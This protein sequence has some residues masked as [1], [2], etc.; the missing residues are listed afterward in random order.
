MT[1]MAESIRM[2]RVQCPLCLGTGVHRFFYDPNDYFVDESLD[3]KKWWYRKTT[4]ESA[5]WETGEAVHRKTFDPSDEDLTL[6]LVRLSAML[7]AELPTRGN[8]ITVSSQSSRNRRRGG[9]QETPRD[10]FI[11]LRKLETVTGGV[12]SWRHFDSNGY[13]P[14][15]SSPVEA[16]ATLFNADHEARLTYPPDFQIYRIFNPSKH[17]NYIKDCRF[18]PGH[19]K[20]FFEVGLPGKNC[21]PVG[22]TER[23]SKWQEEPVAW[24]MEVVTPSFAHV[25]AT[26]NRAEFNL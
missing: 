24:K 6:D 10:F 3:E 18:Q 26:V 9:L 12:L 4:I 17:R 22:W 15:A 14:V 2:R 13:I 23:D 8:M 19:Y 16:V 1:A 5:L 20:L 21:E 11:A 7:E 25:N